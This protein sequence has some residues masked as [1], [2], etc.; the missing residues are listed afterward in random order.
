M[1]VILVNG[2]TVTFSL[3]KFSL[4][5]TRVFL[6]SY[7]LCHRLTFPFSWVVCRNY[8]DFYFLAVAVLLQEL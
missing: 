3:I 5:S 8:R 2:V 1:F 4:A 7:L 6:M